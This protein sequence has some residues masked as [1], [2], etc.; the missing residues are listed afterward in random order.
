MDRFTR[1]ELFSL[2][3]MKAAK[4]RMGTANT[5]PEAGLE[6]GNSCAIK[7]KPETDHSR[8]PVDARNQDHSQDISDYE[9]MPL[10]SADIFIQK[11]T[12]IKTTGWKSEEAHAHHVLAHSVPRIWKYTL[13]HFE[14][15]DARSLRKKLRELL[16]WVFTKEGFKTVAPAP[17]PY[18][19]GG[20]AIAGRIDL[21][22]LNKLDHPILAIE[23]D[24]SKDS[25]S[26]CKL[27]N[28]ASKSITAAWIIGADVVPEDLPS[29]RTF[30]DT[31]SGKS[32]KPW[33]KLI[34]LEHGLV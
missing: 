9:P 2:L 20:R 27:K 7:E 23:A 16:V 15:K 4:S 21:M 6:E 33:L 30:A 17:A 29:W 22:V 31:V 28:L 5:D 14:K 18:Q 26:I 13:T 24:W 1:D 8:L 12:P 25:T 32:S 34:H 11:K 3:G 19:I 10:A